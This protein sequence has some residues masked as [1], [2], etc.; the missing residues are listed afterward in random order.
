MDS[1]DKFVKLDSGVKCLLCETVL[2]DNKKFNLKRHRQSR[3]CREHYEKLS[4]LEK[5][6][7]VET[8]LNKHNISS[9]L[10][11]L[12]NLIANL[13]VENCYPFNLPENF[14]SPILNNIKENFSNDDIDSLSDVHVGRN[15]YRNFIID[16]AKTTRRNLIQLLEKTTNVSLLMDESTTIDDKSVLLVICRYLNAKNEIKEELLIAEELKERT[17]GGHVAD[18]VLNFFKEN[19]SL[20]GKVRYIC[21]D[22]AP[23]MIGLINGA[24][25]IMK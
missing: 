10:K 25:E 20:G 5:S 22:G 24:V 3:K 2:R 17:T 23:S 13:L 7:I 11:N 4:S 8:S 18:I 15:F 21:T 12:E 9:K 16:I 19:H 14:L 1:Y 6:T